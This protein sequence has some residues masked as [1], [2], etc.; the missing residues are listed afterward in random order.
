M[1]VT[2]WAGLVE[3]TATLP[4]PSVLVLTTMFGRPAV[5]VSCAMASP[6][7]SESL[8]KVTV[9]VL[10]PVAATG[11]WQRT[12]TLSDPLV[13]VNGW[14][15]VQLVLPVQPCVVP[16]EK[17][18]LVSVMVAEMTV[19]TPGELVDEFVTAMFWLPVAPSFTMPKLTSLTA[20]SAV[21]PT[22]VRLTFVVGVTGSLLVMVIVP[23]WAPD[24]DGSNW[25]VM[26]WLLPPAIV[27]GNVGGGCSE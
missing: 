4:N 5:Q 7:A 20:M 25:I 11:G 17:K 10:V 12:G 27:I 18:P 6:P 2:V 22:P 8:T 16:N 3:P 1:I 19:S 9:A 26:V 21:V 14:V 24:V 13:T 23:P 15:N